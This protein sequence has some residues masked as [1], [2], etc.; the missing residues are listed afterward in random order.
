MTEPQQHEM[1]KSLPG[2]A[3]PWPEP[4]RWPVTRRLLAMWRWEWER[5]A[6]SDAA[7]NARRSLECRVAGLGVDVL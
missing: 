2:L 5:G 3:T 7:K 4:R 6:H 1:A